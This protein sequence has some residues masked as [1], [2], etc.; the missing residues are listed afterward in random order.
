MRMVGKGFSGRV[1]P[2]FPTMMTQK[3]RKPKRKDTQAPHPSDPS[4]NVADEAIHKELGDSLVRAATTVSSLEAEQD[5]EGFDLEKTKT[6]Q[7]NK[8]ASLKRRVRKLEKKRSS[9]T[10]GLKRLR[11]VGATARVESSGDKE[12]LGENASKQGRINA[13]DADEDITLGKKE[14]VVEEVVDAAQ[15]S[16]AATTVTI[17]T[18]EITLAQALA[19]LK[20]SKPMVKGIAFQEPS[21]TIT[22]TNNNNFLTTII[23]TSGK[24]NNERRTYKPMK[25]ES[26]YHAYEEACLKAKIEADHELA[27]RLQA[28][29]KEGLSVKEKAK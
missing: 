25:K 28:E 15:V 18:K 3:P 11:K 7:A 6:T 12:S 4:D 16:I 19:T 1:T 23:G 13:I 5:S 29:S 20:T 24:E 22:T 17:T 21:T 10:H 26:S 14:N 8:I 9:R 27:Q 2:L